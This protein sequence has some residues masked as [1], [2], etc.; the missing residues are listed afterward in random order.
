MISWILHV[1]GA[2]RVLSCEA[3]SAA[4]A[5]CTFAGPDSYEVMASELSI[6]V[7]RPV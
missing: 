4:Q 2:M 3:L 1:P 7:M 6:E 5:A